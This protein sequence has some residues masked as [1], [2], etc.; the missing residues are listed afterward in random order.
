ML[1]ITKWIESRFTGG[2]NMAKCA[3]QNHC[4]DTMQI[5]AIQ[6][7]KES[8]QF[9]IAAIDAISEKYQNETKAG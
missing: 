3:H 6:K 4:L 9:M 7:L 8:R 5:E 1:K 2:D